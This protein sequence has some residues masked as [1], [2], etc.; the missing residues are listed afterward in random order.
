MA[1]IATL[2]CPK[3]GHKQEM[4]IPDNKCQAFYVCD[5]CKKMIKPIETCCVFCE[6]GDKKCPVASGCC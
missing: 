4:E 3:C 6:Y 2:T 1:E 5:N